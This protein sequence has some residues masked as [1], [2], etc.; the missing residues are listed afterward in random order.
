MQ[1]TVWTLVSELPLILT[2]AP[3]LPVTSLALDGHMCGPSLKRSDV[4]LTLTAG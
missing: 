1:R 3:F 2:V 4:W